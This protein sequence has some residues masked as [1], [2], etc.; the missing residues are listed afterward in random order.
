MSREDCEFHMSFE[1]SKA[2]DRREKR[3][4]R[5]QAWHEHVVQVLGAE[6]EEHWLLRGRRYRAFCVGPWSSGVSNP[7]LGALLSRSGG[8]LP[9]LVLHL[10]LAGPRYGNEI[11]AEIEDLTRGGWASNP[12][13]IYPLLSL[14]E[15]EG[16]IEGTWEGKRKRHRRFYT[17]T[18]EGREELRRLKELI[19][20]GLQ[21]AQQAL[22]R[23]ARELY[24]EEQQGQGAP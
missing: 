12:G 1:W 13:A 14:L 20:P 17:L 15:S 6:A 23:L 11:M 18:A 24:P 7:L 5:C 4:R 2:G 16:L 21:G 9:V 19:R 10:L 22:E 3:R 8:L